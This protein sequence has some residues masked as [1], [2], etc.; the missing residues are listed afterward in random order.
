M[1][2]VAKKDAGIA[3]YELEVEIAASPERVWEAL[4]EETNGWW[5]QDFHMVGSG[6]SV[7]FDARAGGGLIETLPDGG[8]SLLWC[9][10]HWIRPEERTIYLV[11]HIAP[12]WGG[13]TTNHLKLAV[14]PRGKGSVLKVSD[15]HHGNVDDKNLA[16]LES[17]WTTLFTDGLKRYVEEG[18]RRD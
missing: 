12:D 14:E 4:I 16:S 7:A 3:S 6:S 18:L 15:T 13:P 10:V 2:G 5:L 9:T 8:G 11:G 1:N 17:G